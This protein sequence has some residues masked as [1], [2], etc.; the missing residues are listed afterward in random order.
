MV[1]KKGSAKRPARSAVVQPEPDG[2]QPAAGDMPATYPALHDEIKARIR[3]AQVKAALSVN[4]ELIELYWSIGRSIVERQ[5][6]EGWGKAIVEY[7]AADLQ[8]EFPGVSGFSASNIWRMRAFYR[9]YHAMPQFLAQPVRE[10]EDDGLPASVPALPWGHQ[11]IL[12]EKIK[13][14]A[15]RLWYARQTTVNGWSRA[16]LLH[17]IESDFYARQGKAVTNFEQTLPSPQ[18]GPGRG[19]DQGSVHVRLPDAPLRCRRTRA[20]DGLRRLPCGYAPENIPAHRDQFEV[21]TRS[22]R[23]AN[24]PMLDMSDEQR[25]HFEQL[26]RRFHVRRVDLFGSATRHDFDLERSDIDL[27]VE[28]KPDLPGRA[29]DT[30]FSFNEALEALFTCRVDLVMLDAGRNPYIRSEIERSRRAWYAA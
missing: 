21:G 23:V 26:C 28:V 11:V 14:P 16:V 20:R 10:M 3:S 8:R 24:I 1:S 12:I 13:S 29:L 2:A 9:A 5:R 30:Y 4:R 22:R 7:L 18:I 19:T 6:A 25:A 15:E 27:L 17:W